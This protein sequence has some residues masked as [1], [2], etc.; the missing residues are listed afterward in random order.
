MYSKHVLRSS[1]LF[2]THHNLWAH[3]STGRKVECHS[4]IAFKLG[5]EAWLEPWQRNQEMLHEAQISYGIRQLWACH[6][7]IDSFNR[8]SVSLYESYMI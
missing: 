8:L 6:R 1:Y 3:V 2:E 4:I 7:S 5:N